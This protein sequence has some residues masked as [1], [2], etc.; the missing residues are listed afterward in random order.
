MAGRRGAAF[1]QDLFD[2][3]GQSLA[4]REVT[5]KTRIQARRVVEQ[6]TDIATAPLAKL[7][8]VSI[9]LLVGSARKVRNPRSWTFMT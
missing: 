1:A 4:P 2:D 7:E 8:R 5:R 6:L 9:R 3:A